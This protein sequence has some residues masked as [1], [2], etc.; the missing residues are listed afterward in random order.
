[1]SPFVYLPLILCLSIFYLLPSLRRRRQLARLAA[2][3]NC[4][5]PTSVSTP[6]IVQR[7]HRLRAVREHQQIYAHTQRFALYKK[8]TLRRSPHFFITAA[9]ENIKTVLSTSFS[10][11]SLGELRY[12]SFAPLLGK[13]V[14]TLDGPEWK[15]SRELLR[16]QFKRSEISEELLSAG[17]R[18]NTARWLEVVRE[19]EG[20]DIMPACYKLFM[21]NATE[22]LFGKS[23]RSLYGNEADK[24][25]EDFR[26]AQELLIWRVGMGKLRELMTSRSAHAVFERCRRWVEVFVDSELA[27]REKVGEKDQ[28]EGRYVFLRVLAAETQNRDILRDQMLNILLAGRDTTASF[29][30]WTM[31]CLSRHPHVYQKLRDALKDAFPNGSPTFEELKDIKYLQWTLSEVLRLFPPVAANSRTATE[32]TILPQGG[33]EDETHPILV[34]KGDRVQYVVFAM[35]RR[36]DLWGEDAGDFRP[37]RWEGKTHGWEYLPFNGGPRI[38]LGMQ[39]AQSEIGYVVVKVVERYKGLEPVG[40]GGKALAE[41]GK[42]EMLVSLTMAPREVGIRFVE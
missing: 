3:N 38:C 39:Y 12:P 35:H 4:L 1:M 18:D 6:A 29:L 34:K 30:G 2:A 9:P 40:L 31:Y 7:F 22:F 28:K 8:H 10:S 19:A 25:E 41:W 15:H 21:D 16:P 33:G 14:F 24:F 36:T 37:E 32:D 17:L 11:F 23:T 5:E 42:E 13:G 27:R 20:Q 26:V